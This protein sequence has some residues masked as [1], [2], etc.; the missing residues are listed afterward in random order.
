LTQKTKL[1]S[2][3]L[4]LTLFPPLLLM[5]CIFAYIF[6]TRFSAGLPLLHTLSG[7]FTDDDDGEEEATLDPGWW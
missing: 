3:C 1:F 4:L 2:Y 5:A 6:C 7:D